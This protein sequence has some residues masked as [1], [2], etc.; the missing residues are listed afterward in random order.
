M[1]LR[2]TLFLVT[3]G[4]VGI[5]ALAGCDSSPTPTPTAPAPTA[6]P[7][8]PPSPTAVPTNTPL[9]PTPTPAPT[10][11][12]P[13]PTNTPI[14]SSPTPTATNTFIPAT[15]APTATPTETEVPLKFAAPKLVSP[16]TGDSVTAGRDDIIFRWAP[17]G[18]LGGNECY[19]LT[20]RITNATTGQ[21]GEQSFIAQPTCNDSGT[22]DPVTFVVARRAPAPDY[23][24]LV[25]IAGDGGPY[26]ATWTITAVQNN[27]ADPDKPDPSQYI[28]ISPTSAPFEFEI[29]E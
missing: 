14:P 6:A 2:H 29:R 4:L 5:L 21:Y 19:L 17:V 8:S 1:N 25:A 10:I 7:T 13:P 18:P 24:G 27:G 23:A 3:I 28:P 9:P 20:L 16:A 15:A 12:L 11:T 26:R 22:T